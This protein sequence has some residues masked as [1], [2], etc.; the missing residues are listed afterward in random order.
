[1]STLKNI[2]VQVHAMRGRYNYDNATTIRCAL[3]LQELLAQ[4]GISTCHESF[5]LSHTE[6]KTI[7]AKSIIPK[8]YLGF[9]A[10]K[11][12]S[13]SSTYGPPTRIHFPSAKDPQSF[14][15]HYTNSVVI[16]RSWFDRSNLPKLL[17]QYL[18]EAA[19]APIVTNNDHH[20]D[21]NL[22]KNGVIPIEISLGTYHNA[23]DIWIIEA[24][25]LQAT[26]AVA[27]ALYEFL[28]PPE[29]VPSPPP[30]CLVYKGRI[31]NLSDYRR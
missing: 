17:E 19:L 23:N 1:M 13:R 8:I 25:R 29:S 4:V 18:A 28:K 21:Y 30:D 24:R 16:R 15:D 14:N 9:R 2:D 12:P 26:Y 10:I 31:Y 20:L 22:V 27:K 3:K 11:L 7:C 6:A 5:N